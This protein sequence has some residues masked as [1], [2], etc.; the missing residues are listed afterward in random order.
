MKIV[1]LVG[2]F[3]DEVSRIREAQQEVVAIQA[4][5]KKDFNGVGV[6]RTHL[7]GTVMNLAAQLE[8]TCHSVGLAD[9][10]SVHPIVSLRHPFA[11]VSDCVM[12][13]VGV[14]GS[15]HRLN[16]EGGKAKVGK[17][18]Q[19]HSNRN[20]YDIVRTVIIKGEFCCIAHTKQVFQPNGTI[21]QRNGLLHAVGAIRMEH[22]IMV[23][24]KQLDVIVAQTGIIREVNPVFPRCGK[25]FAFH[26]GIATAVP[27]VERNLSIRA[28][29]SVLHRP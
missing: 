10:E 15:H 3:K 4:A 28:S 22:R 9:I 14:V 27:N 13:P 24:S 16:G 12:Y 5:G 20:D 25:I 18:A 26:Q 23:I 17:Y 2:I 11:L 8:G 19:L 6:T 21:R 29:A 1:A 7:Q